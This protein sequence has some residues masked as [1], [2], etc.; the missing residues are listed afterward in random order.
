MFGPPTADQAVTALQGPY[1]SSMAA[2]LGLGKSGNGGY[3]YLG[4]AAG[5]HKGPGSMPNLS[6]AHSLTDI[7]SVA[8]L[9]S[10][11]FI[12]SGPAAGAWGNSLYSAGG[13]NLLA[14][15]PQHLDQHRQLLEL[16]QALA[17]AGGTHG[18]ADVNLQA[19]L[20]AAGASAPGSA[21]SKLQLLE[22][23]QALIAQQQ[24]QLQLQLQ[25]QAGTPAAVFATAPGN[26]AGLLGPRA[27][28]HGAAA[29]DDVMFARDQGMV[30]PIYG[31]TG[32]FR[33]SKNNLDP[34][35]AAP[36]RLQQQ[37]QKN[38]ARLSCGLA[39]TPTAL[40]ALPPGLLDD[41]VGVD[42]A[43]SVVSQPWDP[44]KG[45]RRSSSN[46][47]MDGTAYHVKAANSSRLSW[48]S[49]PT[50]AA[51]VGGAG[52]PGH[53][54]VAALQQQLQQAIE[55]LENMHISVNTAARA[56]AQPAAPLP[57][58]GSKGWEWGTVETLLRS[59]SS[60]SR[61]SINRSTSGMTSDSSANTALWSDVPGGLVAAVPGSVLG[62]PSAAAAHAGGMLGSHMLGLG[63]PLQRTPSNVSCSS[64]ISGCGTPVFG[65]SRGSGTATRQGSRHSSSFGGGAG[66]MSASGDGTGLPAAGAGAP[67]TSATSGKQG[68]SQASS[69]ESLLQH[70]APKWAKAGWNPKA[71]AAQAPAA[72]S[73]GT[74]AFVRLNP[75]TATTAAS[76]GTSST[77]A[78]DKE[79]PP[80]TAATATKGTGAFIPP[81]VRAALA[82]GLT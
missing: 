43:A 38:A 14:E 37:Q 56:A 82:A 54:S 71:A 22:Q 68:R 17:P 26:T 24:Q 77:G 49:G 73:K 5:L 20:A 47:S 79:S 4:N 40:A 6:A 61:G 59:D 9:R 72:A 64:S 32:H 29:S 45:R 3:C 55:Q 25:A 58:T 39:D 48:S 7:D 62:V 36:N 34:I 16:A 28:S 80:K 18:T 27:S 60:I 51:A 66:T 78:A 42:A 52:A 23:L 11:S 10:N 12:S 13:A 46:G 67:G 81:A 31:S 41:V 75:D 44:N 57:R 69:V 53:A 30:A 63:G 21:H 1:D 50:S 65:P 8:A 35:C 70:C 76:N 2:G 15:A 74:G 19:L 33:G